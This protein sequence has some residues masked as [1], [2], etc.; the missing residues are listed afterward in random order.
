[1]DVATNIPGVP[2]GLIWDEHGGLLAGRDGGI[3]AIPSEGQP[4]PVTTTGE[5]SLLH[6]LPSLLPGGSTLLYTVRNRRLSWGDEEV[7]GQR[8]PSGERKV[9]LTDAADARYV[10]SGHLVFLRRGTLCAV[11]FDAERLEKRG[12]EA[13]VRDRVVQALSAGSMADATGAG[14]F[15]VSAAGT[16][17]YLSGPVVAYPQF[18]LVTVDRHGTVTPVPGASERSYATWVRLSPD[19][20]RLAVSVRILTEV[21]L[22][23]IDLTRPAPLVPLTTDGEAIWPVWRRGTE[24]LAFLWIRNGMWALATQPAN[25]T[26]PPQVL[27]PGP[28]YA[29]SVGPDGRI[30]AV[31]GGDIVT[32]TVEIGKAHVDPLIQTPR[33]E[34]SPQFSPDGHWLLYTSNLTGRNEVYVRAYPGS[35]ESVPV[36]ADG[37]W[38]PAWHPGG[39]EVFF[40]SQIDPAGKYRMMTVVFTPGARPTV[41]KPTELFSYDSRDLYMACSPVRCYDV[42]EDGQRFYAVERVASPSLPPVTHIDLIQNWFEE[43]RAKVPV[44]R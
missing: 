13:P 25:G 23:V 18:R 9:L 1:V 28:I 20:R 29:S 16:L 35:G 7:V 22:A 26:A 44:G 19:R 40:V 6:V 12:R 30:A 32:V 4:S 33:A 24:E 5:G 38:S 37:G 10:P 2:T 14:Q 39:R 8:L 31:T 42:A 34:N 43:L 17:A 21:G 36:S 3:W 41:G 11:P 27:M 15:A